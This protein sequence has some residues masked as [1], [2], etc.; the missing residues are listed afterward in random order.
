MTTSW[1]PTLDPDDPKPLYEQILEAVA[2]AISTGALQNGEQ[3]PSVRQLAADLRLNPNTTAR[4]LRALER[5]G[6]L[7]SLRGIGSV[8][9]D[10]ALRRARPLAQEALR[11]ELAGTVEVAR[12]M[13]LQWE[14]LHDALRREWETSDAGRND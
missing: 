3:F 8:V 6:L 14:E 13:G 12:R 10:D 5:E 11:R 7:R 1:R 2:I 9:D 4:A